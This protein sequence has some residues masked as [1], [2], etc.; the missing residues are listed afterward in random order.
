MLS[1]AAGAVELNGD[2]GGGGGGIGSSDSGTG[3][4]NMAC[5]GSERQ[6]ALPGRQNQ[7]QRTDGGVGLCRVCSHTLEEKGQHDGEGF[8]FSLV[9]SVSPRGRKRLMLWTSLIATFAG[10]GGGGSH[11]VA[12]DGGEN[13]QGRKPTQKREI[14]WPIELREGDSPAAAAREF[15]SERLGLAVRP[16]GTAPEVVVGVGGGSSARGGEREENNA[17]VAQQ[18]VGGAAA[19]A[20]AG[21]RMVRFV[22]KQL[23]AELAERQ[24]RGGERPEYVY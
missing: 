8:E 19:A 9:S 24:V 11:A 20:A 13:G 7:L 2:V 12:E 14:E 4:D 1:S 23:E 10:G 6:P 5:D 22:T 18:H 21:E 15:V 17:P 16:K 3:G